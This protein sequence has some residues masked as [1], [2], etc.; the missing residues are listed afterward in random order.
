M[1]PIKITIFQLFGAGGK[2]QDAKMALAFSAVSKVRIVDIAISILK[3]KIRAMP[4]IRRL[5]YPQ[6]G[7]QVVLIR[8]EDAFS[9]LWS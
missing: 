7:F 4:L 6:A 5:M 3:Y 1:P 9:T 8:V 2:P